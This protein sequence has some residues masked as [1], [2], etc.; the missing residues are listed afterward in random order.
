MIRTFIRGLVA[1][2][3][4]GWKDGWNEPIDAL[5]GSV[6]PRRTS[7][8][9]STAA[10]TSRPPR[11]TQQDPFTCC[12][13]HWGITTGLGAAGGAADASS[14]GWWNSIDSYIKSGRKDLKGLQNQRLT[15]K[16][17]EID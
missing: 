12:Y 7:I 6:P 1:A 4:E 9:W 10:S 2:V 13:D 8:W 3:V 5:D 15:I 17:Q 16:L 11:A 14:D